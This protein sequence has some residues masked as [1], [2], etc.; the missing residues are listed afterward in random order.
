VCA[1]SRTIFTQHD[2]SVTNP[3]KVRKF[4]RQMHTILDII[5]IMSSTVFSLAPMR[6]KPRSA[7]ARQANPARH[8]SMTSASPVIN[9]APSSPQRLWCT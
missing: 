7:L 2:N 9:R 3:D 6:L 1:I 8:R 5:T 4:S